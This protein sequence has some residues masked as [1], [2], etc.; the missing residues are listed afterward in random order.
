MQ[1]GEPLTVDGMPVT[2]AAELPPEAFDLTDYTPLRAPVTLYRAFRRVSGDGSPMP[3][4]QAAPSSLAA[5]AESWTEELRRAL[6]NAGRPPAVE[7]RLVCR[8]GHSLLWLLR[9]PWGHVPVART[10]DGHFTL[11]GSGRLDGSPMTLNQWPAGEHLPPASCAC[12]DEVVISVHQAK[13]WFNRVG[14]ASPRDKF[15]H[16]A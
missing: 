3:A 8:K 15:V 14:G 13:S 5:Q 4:E 10:A 1:R 2:E 7:K 11:R 9:S 6:A 16:Q 12:H